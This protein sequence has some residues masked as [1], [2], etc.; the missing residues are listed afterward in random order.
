[1]SLIN[2]TR[3]IVYT[4]HTLINISFIFNGYLQSY[5]ARDALAKHIYSQLF[6]WIVEEVNKALISASEKHKFIG[7]LDIYG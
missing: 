1:M 5:F 7:V 3:C 4:F 2:Y 6:K